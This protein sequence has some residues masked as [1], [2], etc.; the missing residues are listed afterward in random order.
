M[1]RR[2]GQLITRD[3]LIEQVWE[4]RALSETVLSGAISRVRRALGSDEN[5]VVNV[6]GLGYRF[7][8]EVKQSNVVAPARPLEAPFVGRE[9]ALEVMQSALRDAQAGRG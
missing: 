8:G 2:P 6:H 1:L 9:G 4:G 7:T 5:L 3:E